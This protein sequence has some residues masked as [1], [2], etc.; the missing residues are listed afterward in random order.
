MKKIIHISFWSLLLAGLLVLLGFVSKKQ[1]AM[2]CKSLEINIKNSDGNFF[3][4]QD[5]IKKMIHSK[6]DSIVNQPFSTVNIFGLENTLDNNAYIADAEVYS[7]VNGDVKINVQQRQPLV[8]L[9]DKDGE[10]FYIDV[11]G[12]LM[13]LSDEYTSRVL[14]VNGNLQESYAKYYND[15]MNDVWKDST[16]NKQTMLGSIY[17]LAT[18]INGDS[19]LKAQ[20][21][22][23]Y[24]S[25]DSDFVLIPRVGKNKIVLGDASDLDEKFNK[26]KVFYR[27]GLNTTG[28]WDKYAIINLKFKDQIVCTKK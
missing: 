16:L 11:T 1:D 24:V 26:L 5:D 20:F 25:E 17:T 3:I 12:K 9:F 28:W 27:E 8:R 14:V 10:S 2:L 18:Y 7:T 4:N 6:G 19:L 23:I 22:Q 15:N 21:E 13:P